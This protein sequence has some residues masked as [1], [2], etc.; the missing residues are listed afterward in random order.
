MNVSIYAVIP[1]YNRPDYLESAIK[2]VLNQT[3]PTTEVIIVDDCS[4]T[5]LLPVISA[6]EYKRIHYHKSTKNM[7]NGYSENQGT[8]LVKESGSASHVYLH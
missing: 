1:S 7:G 8:K 5:D 4:T 6:Y 3:Y 2:S